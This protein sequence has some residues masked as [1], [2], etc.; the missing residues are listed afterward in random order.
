LLKDITYLLSYAFSSKVLLLD[1]PDSVSGFVHDPDSYKK[2]KREVHP[3]RDL[4][5]LDKAEDISPDVIIIDDLDFEKEKELLVHNEK[6]RDINIVKSFNITLFDMLNYPAIL[7]N[8]G[9]ESN[10]NVIYKSGSVKYD[11]IIEFVDV[12]C[13]YTYTKESFL[14]I[15]KGKIY[16]EKR[17]R[18]NGEINIQKGYHILT[19]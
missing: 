7:N 8:L 16:H 19:H 2:A 17:W 18:K 9:L 10:N 1:R 4:K 12:N 5:L 14:E 6:R 15:E 13:I 11:W 3:I